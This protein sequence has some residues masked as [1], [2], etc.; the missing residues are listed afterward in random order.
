MKSFLSKMKKH[1]TLIWLI[2]VLLLT[3]TF[4][5]F[6]IYTGLT[7]VKRVVTTQ[8]APGDDLFSSNCMRTT[9]VSKKVN[10][11]AFDA[12]VC[13]YDQKDPTVGNSADIT[14]RLTAELAVL[15]ENEYK[16]LTE[17]SA[18]NSSKYAEYV[19]TLSSRTYSIAKTEDDSV[20]ASG[21]S[22][23]V[24]NSSNNYTKVFDS[25]SLGKNHPIMD[26]FRLTFDPSEGL[27]TIPDFY[28]KLT[29]DQITPNSLVPISCVVGAT[30]STE[31]VAAWQGNLLE[32]DCATVDY[33]FYNYII[34]GS[35][36]GTLEIRW[37]D[38]KFEINP[39]FDDI[40]Q[41]NELHSTSVI[42]VHITDPDDGTGWSYIRLNVDSAV[43]DRYEIQ[44]YKTQS[45]P[46]TGSEAALKY[47][48]CIYTED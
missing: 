10:G 42:P 39:F 14:Y 1:W 22:A 40:L 26:K 11:T 24:L 8:A 43:Q 6:A 32:S 16:T 30:M 33:D 2:G 4:I 29:V 19:Q 25:E 28:I 48:K 13:N 37:R 31:N 41:H 3:V 20:A 12:T 35:G 36:H 27:D 38:D 17:L 23:I 45:I 15:Y 46:Y 44:F 34:T 9:L 5:T 7:S 47:L 18:L 21:S